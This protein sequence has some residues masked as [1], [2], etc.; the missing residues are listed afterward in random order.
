MDK[1]KIGYCRVGYFRI[2]CVT[3]HWDRF[4]NTL[5]NLTPKNMGGIDPAVWFHSRWFY[6]RWFVLL[7]LFDEFKEG[8]E[9]HG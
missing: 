7:P 1:A 6:S 9:K 5:E 4:K 3:D 2:G 8:L